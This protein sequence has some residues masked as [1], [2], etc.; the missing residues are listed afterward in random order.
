MIDWALGMAEMQS[1]MQADQVKRQQA[2]ME[3]KSARR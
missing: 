1:E 3:A 2:A